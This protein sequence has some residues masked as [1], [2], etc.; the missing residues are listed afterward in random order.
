MEVCAG[1]GLVSKCLRLS[2]VPTASL[3]IDYWA[4]WGIDNPDVASRATR[5]P[6]DL[7]EPPGMATFV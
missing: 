7:L 1:E 3:D 5:N 6:L 4:K 2:G